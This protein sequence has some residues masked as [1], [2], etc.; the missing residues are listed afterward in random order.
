MYIISVVHFKLYS[1]AMRALPISARQFPAGLNVGTE[2]RATMQTA[3]PKAVGVADFYPDLGE[4]RFREAFRPPRRLFLNVHI[5][6]VVVPFEFLACEF[7]VNFMRT[8]G[9]SEVSRG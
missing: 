9:L 4:F 6:H 5:D 3:E 8:V 1:V 2:A 7:D